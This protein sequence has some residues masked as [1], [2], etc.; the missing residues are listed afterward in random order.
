ML[1]NETKH[2]VNSQALKVK[3]LGNHC[4]QAVLCALAPYLDLDEGEALKLMAALG[5]GM[6]HDQ[7]CGAVIAAGVALGLAF[8]VDA[9]K[10]TPEQIKAD[11]RLGELTVEFVER[12]KTEIGTTVCG[13][14]LKSELMAFDWDMP[15][16]IEFSGSTDNENQNRFNLKKPICGAAITQATEI[17]LD[18]I[19]R[20]RSASDQP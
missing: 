6:R 8:G 1:S 20:E 5:G 3:S 18:I 12:F 7:L 15:E 16:D 4:S 17:A 10:K 13:E 2:Q 19:L 14:I 11:E 9:I